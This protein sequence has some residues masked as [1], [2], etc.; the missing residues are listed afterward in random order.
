MAKIVIEKM[1][2]QF[3]IRGYKGQNRRRKN[4]LSKTLKAAIKIT[5]PIRVRRPALVKLEYI[6]QE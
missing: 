5:S 2:L 1:R 4:S 6:F 3:V